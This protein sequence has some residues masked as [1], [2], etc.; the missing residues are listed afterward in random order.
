MRSLIELQKPE[1]PATGGVLCGG[2][3]FFE[4]FMAKPFL[5]YDAQLNKLENEKALAIPDREYATTMLQ[6]IGYFSL[7]GGY[8]LPFKNPTNNLYYR[9]VKFDDIVS[10]Y[11]FDE[12]LIELVFKY[13]LQIERHVRSLLAYAFTEKHGELQTEY[14]DPNNYDS[15]PAAQNDVNRLIGTL[16]NLANRTSDYPYIN[17]QR[18]AYGNVP[19]WVLMNG[20]TFGTLSKFY[21]L[22]TQ[23]IKA[24]VAKNFSH[25]NEKQLSQY[26]TVMTKF[27]NVCAHNERLFSYNT[28]DDIP[29][30]KLHAKLAIP[31]RGNQFLSGKRDLFAMVIAFPYLLP[32]EEFKAFKHSLTVT[33][34]NYFIASSAIPRKKLLNY[35]GFPENWN[36]ITR[37]KR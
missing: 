3:L 33:I 4:V 14:L 26:L 25:V 27:R 13:I 2:S 22:S 12:D 23:D 29:D 10:L 35:M 20:I 19:L 31:K 30:T 28:R 16:D 8:K 11:V 15:D 21:L 37:Y 9:H 5:S 7:I 24:K 34:N 32:E 6:R 1:R 36:R 18:N 17:H